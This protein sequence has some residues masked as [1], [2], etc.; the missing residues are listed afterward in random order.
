MVKIMETKVGIFG[1]AMTGVTGL[2][3]WAVKN[4][5]ELRAFL[6]LLSIGIAILTALW[7]VWNWIARVWGVF[8]K[9][10]SK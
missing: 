4:D 1:A 6:L 5:A 2:L 10:K 9:K 3:S 7:W 8:K